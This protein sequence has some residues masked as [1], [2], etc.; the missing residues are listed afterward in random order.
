LYV[1][2]KALTL[3][4]ITFGHHYQTCHLQRWYL[5]NKYEKVIEK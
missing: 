4:N 5:K 3:K 1:T 2:G